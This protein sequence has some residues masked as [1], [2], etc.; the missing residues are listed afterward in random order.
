MNEVVNRRD[1]R[2]GNGSRL[3]KGSDP[4]WWSELGA[5]GG[6]GDSAPSEALADGTSG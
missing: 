4:K 3:G 5:R 6:D 2:L 1:H